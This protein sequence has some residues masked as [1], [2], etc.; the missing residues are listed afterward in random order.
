MIEVVDDGLGMVTE[1]PDPGGRRGIGL[2]NVDERLRVIY[3]AN[4][5]LKL[6]SA[7]GEGTRARIEIP[8]LAT[9]RAA[10]GRESAASNG[11]SS[12]RV[13]WAPGGAEGDDGR[14]RSLRRGTTR[15][16]G[17]LVGRPAEPPGD[18]GRAGAVVGDPRS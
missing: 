2:K 9:P 16:P 18:D 8:E 15:T 10:A 14:A 17:G 3:G 7:P 1:A 6:N 5:H 13:G 12:S 11:G 4:Y